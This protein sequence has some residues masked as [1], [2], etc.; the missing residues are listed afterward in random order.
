MGT[1]LASV[2]EDLYT[3]LEVENAALRDRMRD[4][5][6]KPVMLN[7]FH[8]HYR[9]QLQLSE[10]EAKNL[11]LKYGTVEDA[12]HATHP[13]REYVKFHN[14]YYSSKPTIKSKGKTTVVITLPRALE[15][16]MEL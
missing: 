1:Y 7:Q 14:Q 12:R 8:K 10:H 5:V 3:A 4:C 2:A 9:S 16:L 11:H 15:R 6:A 13:G